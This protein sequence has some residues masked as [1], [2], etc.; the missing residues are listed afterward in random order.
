MNRMRPLIIASIFYFSSGCY[1][2]ADETLIVEAPFE[3]SISNYDALEALWENDT[4]A[5][6][7]K[8]VLDVASKW[9]LSDIPLTVCFM[10]GEKGDRLRVKRAV[11]QWSEAIDSELFDFGSRR[12]PQTCK[13]EHPGENIRISFEGNTL[14]SY[15]GQ[16]GI[17][18]VG[19]H[20]PTMYLGGFS[21]SKPADDKIFIHWVLHEFGHALG[22]IHE[23]QGEESKCEAEYDLERIYKRLESFPYNW[24]RETA[25][26]NINIMYLDNAHSSTFDADSIM[27]YPLPPEYYNNGE[28]SHCYT[29]V[30]A[31]LSKKD[32]LFANMFYSLTS[33]TENKV[34]IEKT[35]Y[36]SNF[37]T[38]D[39]IFRTNTPLRNT[40]ISRD[41]AIEALKL[42]IQLENIP[43]H[44]KNA[45]LALLE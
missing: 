25:I 43:I 11:E 26:R 30:H 13:G 42:K 3:I 16:I 38:M 23:Q 10:D 40:E 24:D 15:R 1:S 35:L 36:P 6:S 33:S 4:N 22:L 17:Q 12:K 44:E 29:E 41:A 5:N 31:R 7:Y 19:A 8:F 45:L 37:N 39:E 14:S 28:D 34:I 21:D 20:N 9:K 27:L 32:K 18:K 2:A